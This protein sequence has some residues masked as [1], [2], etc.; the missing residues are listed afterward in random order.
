MVDNQSLA[1]CDFILATNIASRNGFEEWVCNGSVPAT[2]ICNNTVS[3][4]TGISQCN[5]NEQFKAIQINGI[6]LEGSIPTSFSLL[7]SL[8]RLVAYDNLLQNTIPST[9]SKLKDLRYFDVGTNQ[10][11]GT[12]PASFGNLS[13]LAV[14]LLDHNEFSGSIPFELC[15]APIQ[16]IYANDNP[17]MTCYASCLSSATQSD[18]GTLSVCAEGTCCAFF[19]VSV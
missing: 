3:T 7:S 9:L 6:G 19:S 12:V 4:W 16:S 8:T 18:F 10:I 17:L 5:E 15:N 1:I 13:K 14:L 2:N 11:N